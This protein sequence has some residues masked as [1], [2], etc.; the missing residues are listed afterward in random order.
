MTSIE[1]GTSSP[2]AN[3]VV[4]ISGATSAAIASWIG[5]SPVLRHS[6]RSARPARFAAATAAIAKIG[7]A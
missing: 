5:P 1:I 3:A 6:T 7:R 2:I 4:R